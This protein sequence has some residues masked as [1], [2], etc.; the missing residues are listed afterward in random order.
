MGKHPFK[1]KEWK[2]LNEAAVIS[3]ER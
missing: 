2:K 3:K 1:I